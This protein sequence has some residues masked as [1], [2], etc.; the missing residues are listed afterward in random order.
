LYETGKHKKKKKKST[1]GQT[2]GDA[3]KRKTPSP[4]QNRHQFK[5]SLEAR[6]VFG[7]QH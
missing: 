6:L 3:A 2:K 1:K 7:G 5:G 4:I